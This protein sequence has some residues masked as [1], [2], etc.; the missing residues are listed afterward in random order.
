MGVTE[1]MIEPL[2]DAAL[3]DH[4]AATNPRPLGGT[5]MAELFAAAMS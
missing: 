3:A 2:I 4:C 5:E 1:A